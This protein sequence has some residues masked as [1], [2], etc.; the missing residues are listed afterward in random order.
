MNPVTSLDQKLE[1]IA[2]C[3]DELRRYQQKAMLNL[4]EAAIYLSLSK[5]TLY[6]HTSA[7]NIPYYK[8]NGKLILFSR[9]DLDNWLQSRRIPSNNELLE[10]SFN[11][12]G[13]SIY[14]SAIPA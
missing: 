14:H 13:N 10:R 3:L 12:P 9:S 7:G 5:S 4:E 2:K 8:P 6:K 1:E 11:L